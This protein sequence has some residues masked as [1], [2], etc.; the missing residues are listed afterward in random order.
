MQRS[1]LCP[2]HPDKRPSCRVE[3]DKKIFHC[4]ACEASGNILEFVARIEGDADDLRSAAAKIADICEIAL[5]AAP[6][7]HAKNDR[8]GRVGKSAARKTRAARAPRTE[9]GAADDEDEDAAAALT[10][11]DRRMAERGRST[12]RSPSSS[13]SIPSTRTS[14]SA[15]SRPKLVAEFGLGYCSRGVMAGRICI[16][17]HNA[18]G[19]LVAYAGRWPG[20][21]VPEESERYQLPKKFEKV[22]CCST[23][24]A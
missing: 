6:Q 4:F 20:D 10:K 1:V 8:K 15:A 7:G 23:C 21:D 14:S 5:A 9:A 22:G 18:A 17:I 24:I 19:E 2:F 3:L 12:R 16:P 11:A 13:S